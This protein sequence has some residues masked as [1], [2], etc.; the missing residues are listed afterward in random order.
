MT[1]V[2]RKQ[3]EDDIL[4]DLYGEE[5]PHSLEDSM[6]TMRPGQDMKMGGM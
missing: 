1:P 2:V 5:N 6:K 4:F 3:V